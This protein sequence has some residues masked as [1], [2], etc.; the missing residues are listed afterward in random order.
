MQKLWY[1]HIWTYLHAE[2]QTQEVLSAVLQPM[3]YIV[4]SSTKE[5]YERIVFPTLKYVL[6][7]TRAEM[8]ARPREIGTSHLT[9]SSISLSLSLPPSLPQTSLHQSKV[10]SGNRDPAGES[11]HHPG[12]DAPGIRARGALD[13]VHVL[14]EFDHSSAGK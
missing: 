10:D 1:Q 6:H 13:A 8:S 9:L 4:Q 12:E 3:L 7:R 5:E 14:R 11:A 2:L